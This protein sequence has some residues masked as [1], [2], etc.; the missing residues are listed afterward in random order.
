MAAEASW[1]VI[2]DWFFLGGLEWPRRLRGQSSGWPGMA[3][4]ASWP[5]LCSLA[6]LGTLQKAF[7]QISKAFKQR[8]KAL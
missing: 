5:P 3:A 4:E 8:L 6:F 2:K 1:P 7:E